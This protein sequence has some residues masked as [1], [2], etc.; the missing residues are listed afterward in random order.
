MAARA[1]SAEAAPEARGGKERGPRLLSV[2]RLVARSC[3]ARAALAFVRADDGRYE[4]AGATRRPPAALLGRL[5]AGL[6]EL[7]GGARRSVL[8]D[9]T[10]LM[11]VRAGGRRRGA[12]IVGALVLRHVPRLTASVAADMVTTL[13]PEL[14]RAAERE[15]SDGE[16]ERRLRLR[17]YRL[18]T[19]FDLSRTLGATFHPGTILRSLATT[20]IGQ[21]MVSRVLVL[22]PRAS[23]AGGVRVNQFPPERALRAMRR[24]IEVLA[25]EDV[26]TATRRVPV[27]DGAPVAL[28][29]ASAGLRRLYAM[30]SAGEVVGVVAISGKISGLPF[31]DE[32]DEFARILVNQAAMALGNARLLR[33]TV[34]RERLQRELE[35][36]RSIQE[37]I[38]PVA[39]AEYGALSLFGKTQP[40]FEVGGDYLDVIPLPDGKLLLAV[41]D[42][43]GKGVPAAILMASIAASVRALA[44]SAPP[45]D[46]G[47]LASLLTRVNELLLHTT[48]KSRFASFIALTLDLA[49]GRIRYVNAGHGPGLLVTTGRPGIAGRLDAGGMP[50]GL[51]ADVNYD[52]GELEMGP[53]QALLLFTD[54]IAECWEPAV[55]EETI[56]QLAVTA[57]P[58][59]APAV[60]RVVMDA[61][62]GRLRGGDP[63]DDMTLL[64][65]S[66]EA[67]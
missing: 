6:V 66:W 38:V 14:G 2:L 49:S 61:V 53:G 47:G 7:E 46:R 3:G 36:A 67:A 22:R 10:R 35:L 9:G 44:R 26:V 4:L 16:L 43:S 31:T 64:C 1:A 62:G 40:C 30:E 20:L 57:L 15:R 50:L 63:Q 41:G 60:H 17:V 28:A 32:D 34:A 58:G 12:P 51:F 24:R 8:R 33:Q 25:W 39:S 19:I 11:L 5:V 56:A 54:G 45:V 23:P 65:L 27:G 52:E 55:A 37:A 42:I 21:L 18:H 29:L 59:P 48:A 13:A